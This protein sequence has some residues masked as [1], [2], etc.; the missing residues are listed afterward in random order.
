MVPDFFTVLFLG[1]WIFILYMLWKTYEMLDSIN[2]KLAEITE[3]L[4]N[5]PGRTPEKNDREGKEE[6][7]SVRFY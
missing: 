7:A 4:K 3:Y 6:D 1:G 5:G 2:Q